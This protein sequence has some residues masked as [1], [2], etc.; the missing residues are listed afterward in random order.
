MDS[1][2]MQTLSIHC[3][4]KFF[5]PLWFSQTLPLKLCFMPKWHNK[6]SI[7][8]ELELF[9]NPKLYVFNNPLV[10]T[11]LLSALHN[12]RVLRLSVRLMLT[13][14]EGL[15]VDVRLG[16]IH[17]SENGMTASTKYNQKLPLGW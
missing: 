14:L 9:Y 13:C 7:T 6:R 17:H 4:L 8:A 2:T 15:R 10:R 3:I 1:F 16:V 12:T 11:L 5:L